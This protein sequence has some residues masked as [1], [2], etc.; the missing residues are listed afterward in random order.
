VLLEQRLYNDARTAIG[1][2]NNAYNA[3][4][5]EVTR[6]YRHSPSC[7]MVV[8]DDVA[9][10]QPY[11]LGRSPSENRAHP[12]LGEHM[13]VLEWQKQQGGHTFLIVEDHFRRLWETSDTDLFHFNSLWDDHERILQQV[14]DQRAAW[15]QHT[16]NVLYRAN[17]SERSDRRRHPR[18]PCDG[19][20]F[21]ITVSLDR[22]DGLPPAEAVGYVCDTSREG[23]CLQFEQEV[24]LPAVGEVRL[25]RSGEV[26]PRAAEAKLCALIDDRDRWIIR[27]TGRRAGFLCAGME[28]V[29]SGQHSINL[30][31]MAA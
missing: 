26:R 15:F 8:A 23:I 22:P 2:L 30:Q 24:L 17:G 5:A 25:R 27:W 11:T 29:T 18:Q 10:Y 1:L 16:Y 9:F 3:P 4:L 31:S 14:L 19:G 6:F 7:W 20:R 21:A 13:P 12:S 28:A